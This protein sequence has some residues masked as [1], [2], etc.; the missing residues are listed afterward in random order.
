MTQGDFSLVRGIVSLPPGA[1][2]SG[3]V[4]VLVVSTHDR[5]VLHEGADVGSGGQ[6]TVTFPEDPRE[7]WAGLRGERSALSRDRPHG[8]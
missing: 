6:F 1:S 5:A 8:L 7:S 4:R 3:G 2:P